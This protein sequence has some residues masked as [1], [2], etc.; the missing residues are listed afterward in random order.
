MMGLY[1]AFSSH[2][3]FMSFYYIIII[4]VIYKTWVESAKKGF[5]SKQSI[6]V[7][8]VAFHYIL[9]VQCFVFKYATRIRKRC[10]KAKKRW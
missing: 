9:N 2:N 7:F 1:K 4:F 10:K 5:T 6:Y 8:I 3:C